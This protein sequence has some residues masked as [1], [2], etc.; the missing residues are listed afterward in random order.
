M[1]DGTTFE[2]SSRTPTSTPTRADH[3][4]RL[5][6]PSRGHRRPAHA[7]DPLP[8][9]ARRRAREGQ[10]YGEDPA[11]LGLGS[12]E[13][14]DL[15][16]RLEILAGLL[17]ALGQDQVEW[18]PDPEGGAGLAAVHLDPAAVGLDDLL[19]DRQAESDALDRALL[20]VPGA[21]EPGEQ[22]VPLRWVDADARVRD[23][24]AR[25]GRRTP[26]GRRRRCHRPACTS[27]RCSPGCRPPG[28]SAA[29]RP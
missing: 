2:D 22:P 19:G 5:R 18:Q 13:P 1:K 8:R 26:S 16:E 24:G 25:C 7:E 27:R 17:V 9:Q 4:R 28:R 21:E 3:R 6:H 12:L 10:A 14:L 23:R 20:G 15:V 11:G 29:G